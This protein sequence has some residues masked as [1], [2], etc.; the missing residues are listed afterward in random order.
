MIITL[1]YADLTLH[2]VFLLVLSTSLAPHNLPRCV[3]KAA[4]FANL[5]RGIEPSHWPPVLRARRARNPSPF[6]NTKRQPTVAGDRC[7]PSYQLL[8]SNREFMCLVNLSYS[9]IQSLRREGH[10]PSRV[11]WSIT[12]RAS[13]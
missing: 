1:S 11:Y 4:L 13:P 3:A 7:K 2:Q 12:A 6:Y 8:S 10:Q 5:Q 9:H